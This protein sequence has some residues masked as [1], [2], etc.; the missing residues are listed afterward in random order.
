MGYGPKTQQIRF[1]C[2]S[3]SPWHLYSTSNILF[4]QKSMGRKICNS[5]KSAAHNN[6]QCPYTSQNSTKSICYEWPEMLIW[7]N[8]NQPRS[9]EA[10]WDFMAW[11]RSSFSE[12]FFLIINVSCL[13]YLYDNWHAFSIPNT[14]QALRVNSEEGCI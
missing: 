4:L 10:L 11:R 6:L 2:K 14:F 5:L 7:W 13:M 12:C 9:S 8:L 1:W 3:E